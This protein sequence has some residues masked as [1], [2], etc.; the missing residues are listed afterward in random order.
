MS[1]V[2][3]DKDYKQLIEDQAALASRALSRFVR[4]GQDFALVDFPDHYNVG[5]S[6]IWLGE[7]ALFQQRLGGLPTYVSTVESYS[8]E[9][10]RRASPAGPI[11]IHGGGN[12]GDIYP[13]HQDFRLRL[14]A[15]FP[16]RDI[17]QLPQSISFSAPAAV[18]ATAEA[19]ARHGRFTLLV[20]DQP[21]LN[22]AQEHFDCA[23]ELLPDMAFGMGPLEKPVAPRSAVF[24]LL[25]EDTERAS[26]DRA[27]L[28]RHPDTVVADWVSEPA[29]FHRLCRWRTRLAMAGKGGLSSPQGTLDLYNRL[30]QGRV[31]R[32]LKMLASGRVVVTDRLHAHILSTM[33]DIPHVVLDNSYGKIAGYM[34]A[35]TGRYGQVRRAKTAGDVLAHLKAWGL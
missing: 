26:Y 33:M 11:F 8:R 22:F 25:R 15:D 13:K 35:W 29:R 16:D 5:D 24:M 31:R 17:V 3:D 7:I 18:T 30:A 6:A 34:G 20:R 32:G 10:L 1:D 4:P 19:I 9:A 27:P 23:A 12:F 14:M 21:S 28:L 2:S